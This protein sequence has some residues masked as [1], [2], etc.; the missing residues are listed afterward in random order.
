MRKWTTKII[1]L[2]AAVALLAGCGSSGSSGSGGASDAANGASGGENG[3]SSAGEIRFAFTTPL[4]GDKA[5][6]GFHLKNAADIAAEKINASGGING[7]KLVI[8]YHDSK[9]DPKESAEI[10]RKVTQNQNYIAALGDFSSSSAMAAAPIYEEAKMVH[11]SPTASNPDF[12]KMGD[13]QYAMYGTQEDDAPFVAQYIIQKYLGLDSVALIY[14]N[15]DWG[16]S[17]L[18]YFEDRAKQIGLNITAKEPIAEGEKDFT[19]ILTKIR[20]TNPDI[21]YMMANASEVANATIQARQSGWDIKIIP[22]SSAVTDQLIEMLGEYAEGL[23][24]NQVYL[25]SEKDQAVWEYAQTFEQKTGVPITYF[26]LLGHDAVYA[27]ATAAANAGDQ[28]NR[29]TLKEE[30]DKLNIQTLLGKLA[31]DEDGKVRRQYKIVGYQNGQ[32]VELAGYEF[33]EQ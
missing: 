1:S 11:L 15:T 4:T 27:L 30:L 5:E 12:V 33:M 18:K 10:A 3:A 28:L 24:T 2:I 7:K 25:L 22:S 16:L 20:Q 31:F 13:Y 6:Y 29:Q 32:W 9:G 19:A 23:I 17:A 14:F 26:S 21:I 8:D